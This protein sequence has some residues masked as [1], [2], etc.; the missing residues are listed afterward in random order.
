MG[1]NLGKGGEPWHMLPKALHDTEQAIKKEVWHY[2]GDVATSEQAALV[3]HKLAA[4][5]AE[6]CAGYSVDRKH[7]WVALNQHSMYI[8]P[9]LARV[10][11]VTVTLEDAFDAVSEL[12]SESKE[13]ITHCQQYACSCMH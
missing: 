11:T 1:M 12:V 8:T 5:R 7:E 4:A 13:S 2:A 3:A 9:A 10:A 6:V